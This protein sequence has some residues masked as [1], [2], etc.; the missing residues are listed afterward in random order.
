MKSMDRSLQ[1]RSNQQG[2]VAMLATIILLTSATAA[3]FITS[4]SVQIQIKK[5]HSEYATKQAFEAA[6]AGLEYATAYLSH[7]HNTLLVDSNA[8]GY[9]DQNATTGSVGSSNAHYSFTLSN[10]HSGNYN[11]VKVTST[12]TSADG[13]SSRTVSQLINFYPFLKLAAIPQLPVTVKGSVTM[14]GN[15]EINNTTSELGIWSGENSQINGSAGLKTTGPNN[16][17]EDD[18]N[19]KNASLEAL[20]KNYFGVSMSN[21]KHHSGV[22]ITDG[23]DIDNTTDAFYWVTPPSGKL[24]L[25]GNTTIGTTQNPVIMVVEGDL[26][27]GGTVA[28]NGFMFVTGDLETVGS[29]EI[30][31]AI[32]VN[33]TLTSTGSSE[34]S[35]NFDILTNT[36]THFGTFVKIPGTWKDH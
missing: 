27:V 20:F 28:F 4:Q 23:T 3:T 14:N 10:L 1:Y 30:N 7:H 24:N 22:H 13:Q 9:L 26:K 2:L 5:T 11:L 31:G 35:Y 34:I 36:A 19:L 21:M 12:G 8:S 25:T 16:I 17:K 18:Q 15:T 6:Q 32:V 29:A 33:G